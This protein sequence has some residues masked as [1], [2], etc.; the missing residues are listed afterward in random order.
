MDIQLFW[1]IIEAAKVE[2]QDDLEARIDIIVNR[3]ES[4]D[5]EDILAWQ[6]IFNEYQSL[7]YKKKLW[8]AAYIINGGCS[9]D[10][11]DYFRGWLTAQGHSVFLAALRDPDSLADLSEVEEGEAECENILGAA[12]SAYLRKLN[13]DEDYDRF[14]E[15]LE[16]HPLSDSDKAAMLSEIR[17]QADIDEDWRDDKELKNQLPRLCEKYDW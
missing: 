12:S 4:L 5:A 1:E 13:L 10:G 11:F 15:D 6:Q 16:G 2:A 9:E 17:Y 8:A 7:S 14:Y 3:L